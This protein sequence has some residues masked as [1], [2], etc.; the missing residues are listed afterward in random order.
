[1]KNKKMPLKNKIARTQEDPVKNIRQFQTEIETWKQLLDSG[2]EENILLK[3]SISDIL[4]NNYDQSCLDEIE[5]FQT[6]FIS[7]DELIHSLKSDVNDS[8]NMLYAKISEHR[9]MEK[10]FYKKMKDLR[11]DVT[12]FTTRFQ[13]L[14]MAFNDFQHKISKRREN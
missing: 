4:K 1:M 8:D 2:M 10:P 11:R 6:Q 13:T 9:K 12:D 7:E 3:N 14:K 5:E